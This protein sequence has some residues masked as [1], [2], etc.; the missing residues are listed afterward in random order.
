MTF[1]CR[2]T[3]FSLLLAAMEANGASLNPEPRFKDGTARNA[4]RIPK[5]KWDEHKELLC[6]LYKKK[7]ITE[8]VAFMQAEHGF[9]AK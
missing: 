3:L 1:S 6:A 9:V 7:T 8:I 4:A 5:E 2:V